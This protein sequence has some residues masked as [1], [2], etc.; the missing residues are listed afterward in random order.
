MTGFGRGL[1]EGPLGRFSVELKSVNSRFLEMKIMLPPGLIAL[2][3]P[4]R[5]LL[6][7]G[8]ERGKVDC[9][10][11]FT[12]SAAIAEGIS[13]NEDLILRYMETLRSIGSRAGLAAEISLESVLRLP[14]VT[15]ESDD[16]HDEELCWPAIEAAARL[17]LDQF[18]TDRRREGSALGEQI[19]ID[20]EAL[21]ARRRAIEEKKGQIAEN[22]RA[23]L[24]ARIAELEE[25]TRAKL[26]GGRLELEVAMLAD[27]LDVTEEMARL[28]AHLDRLAE[29]IENKNGEPVGKALDFL[30]QEILREINTTG[31]KLRDL[32]LV[33]ETLEMKGSLERIR[34]QIQNVE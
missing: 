29:L 1:H 14:G 5:A 9:R 22:F 15:G 20:A 10:V 2:E 33:R 25:Q 12:P 4:L 21:R 7:S 34:E 16:G 27:R 26:D 17:A 18:N 6:K 24:T 19:L 8:I 28:Q 30:V 3:A 31:A 32:E 11:R 23:K 13:F